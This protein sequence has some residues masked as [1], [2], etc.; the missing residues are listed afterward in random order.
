MVLM[1]NFE[2]KRFDPSIP[3]FYPY[4]CN[5][6]FRN[7]IKKIVDHID[8]CNIGIFLRYNQAQEWQIKARQSNT[9]PKE[10]LLS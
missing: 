1:S 7:G 10:R 5:K 8:S 4:I 9:L 6:L 2:D 3:F